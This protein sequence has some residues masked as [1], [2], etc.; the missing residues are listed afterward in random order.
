FAFNSA[1]VTIDVGDTVK[2]VWQDGDIPHSTTSAAGQMEAWD[3]GQ[4]SGNFTFQHTFAHTGTFGY[5]CSVHGSDA[6]NGKGQGMAGVVNVQAATPLTADLVSLTV[7]PNII[8]SNGGNV[9]VTATLG[10]P[11]PAD[12]LVGLSTMSD[13]VFFYTGVTI[14]AGETTGTATTPV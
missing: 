8:A 5:Y 7:S 2:W 3:S 14:S 4:K 11:A 6:G 13:L 12:T 1:N 9:T 10:A